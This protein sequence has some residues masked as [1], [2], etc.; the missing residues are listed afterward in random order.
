MQKATINV[1]R[2]LE[3]FIKSVR[4]TVNIN[5]MSKAA[6]WC[7]AVFC[8]FLEKKIFL[9]KSQDS[10]FIVCC[11]KRSNLCMLVMLMIHEK[12]L[13]GKNYE[14]G[15]AIW[16]TSKHSFINL[17]HKN[18]QNFE[19]FFS[20]S[21]FLLAIS[22][23]FNFHTSRLAMINDCIS[24]SPVFSICFQIIISHSETMKYF[25]GW[26]MEF[27]HLLL[28]LVS[29]LLH[30]PSAITQRQHI[31]HYSWMVLANILIFHRQLL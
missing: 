27:V 22:F 11:C 7:C 30:K 2:H 1:A 4:E 6:R 20:F 10:L 18:S 9:S 16:E 31:S 25:N 13:Q 19:N 29:L 3:L 15:R 5:R 14:A 21:F 17:R 23:F 26:K 12:A 8:V 28:Y 24:F